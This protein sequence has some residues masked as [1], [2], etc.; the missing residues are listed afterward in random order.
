[1]GILTSQN[2]NTPEGLKSRLSVRIH[3]A[4]AL[5][6]LELKKLCRHEPI[7]TELPCSSYE[8]GS[9]QAGRPFNPHSLTTLLTRLH[10]ATTLIMRA[11]QV[12]SSKCGMSPLISTIEGYF[13]AMEELH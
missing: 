2:P 4:P 11:L 10:L 3:T 7:L 6:Q 13:R 9:Q 8:E 1:M 5:D 12:E